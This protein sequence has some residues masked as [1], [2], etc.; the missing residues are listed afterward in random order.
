MFL[1]V[2]VRL[3]ILFWLVVFGLASMMVAVCLTPIL[4]PCIIAH[5]LCERFEKWSRARKPIADG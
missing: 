3:V 5:Y 2:L 4:I 1:Y